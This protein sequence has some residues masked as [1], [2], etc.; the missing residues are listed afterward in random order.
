MTA[1]AMDLRSRNERITLGNGS[2]SMSQHS[3]RLTLRLEPTDEGRI[4]KR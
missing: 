3:H 1:G 2:R 4:C